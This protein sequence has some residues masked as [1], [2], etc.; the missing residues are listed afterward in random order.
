MAWRQLTQSIWIEYDRAGPR[1]NLLWSGKGCPM[2]TLKYASSICFTDRKHGRER[3]WRC[4]SVIFRIS[5][6]LGIRETSY[7]TVGSC[8][9]G[10]DC[11]PSIHILLQFSLTWAC[12]WLSSCQWTCGS[13]VATCRS[14]PVFFLF[15]HPKCEDL[16][17][18]VFRQQSP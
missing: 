12:M 4:L 7:V 6:V 9:R 2:E 17:T 11:L 5:L 16:K 10:C 13:A 18:T 14:G 8:A 1:R 15:S 3:D